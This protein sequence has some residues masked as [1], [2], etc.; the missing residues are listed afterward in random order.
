MSNWKEASKSNP[1]PLC[2]KPDWCSATEDGKAVLCR[3]TDMAPDGWKMLPTRTKDGFPIFAV[4][5]KKAVRPKQSRSWTYCNRNGNPLVRVWRVDDGKGGKPA[6]WQERWTGKCWAKGLED[7]QRHD[8]PVYRYEEVQNAITNDQAIFIVEGEV[9]ADILWGMG[10]PATTNIGGAGKWTASDTTDLTGAKVVLC[11]DRDEPGLR[12]MED[13]FK[14]FPDAQWLFAFPDSLS[15]KNPPKSQGVDVADWVADYKLTADDIKKA[16][17]SRASLTEQE[18]NSG[19]TNGLLG[20]INGFIDQNLLESEL[21]EKLLQ[22]SQEKRQPVQ[23]LW[24]LHNTLVQERERKDHI[25]SSLNGF[26]GLLNHQLRTEQ[27]D[28]NNIFPAPLMKALNSKS[29]AARIQPIFL[30]QNLLPAVGGLMGSG[31]GIVAKEGETEADH[32]IEY[33][34][35]WSATIAPP[36]AGKS[37]ANR[38]MFKPIQRLQHEEAERY[39][40]AILELEAVQQRWD[41]YSKDEKADLMDELDNP[42]NFRE[43]KVGSCR[44]FLLSEGEIEAIKR[45]LSEQPASAGCSWVSDELLGLFKGLDQYK[46]NDRGNARQFLLDAWT[47]PLWGDVERVDKKQS[48][49]FKG[50]TLNLCGGIQVE[51]AAQFFNPDG[52]NTDADGLQ[53]RI[54]VAAPDL[55]SDFDV[56]SDVKVSLDSLLK[57]LYQKVQKLPKGLVS[58][59]ADTKV[60]WQKQWERYR[61]SSRQQEQKNPAFAYFLGKMCS[62]LMRLALVLHAIEHC[63]SPKFDFLTLEPETFKKAIALAGYYISQFR[64]VQTKFTQQPEQ[65]MSEFLLNVLN[66]CLREGRLTPSM[67]VNRWRRKPGKD[68]KSIRSAEVKEMFRV[69]AAARPQQVVFDGKTLCVLEKCDRVSQNAITMRS[70]DRIDKALQSEALSTKYDQCDRS[71]DKKNVIFDDF[72]SRDRSHL[73]IKTTETLATTTEN[74]AITRS[75]SDHILKNPIAFSDFPLDKGEQVEL[76]RNQGSPAIAH[77]FEGSNGSIDATQEPD[78]IFPKPDRVSGI[79]VGDWVRYKRSAP[80]GAMKVTCSKHRLE[81]LKLWEKSAL[82]R[83]ETWSEG[84]WIEIKHLEVVEKGSQPAS[85]EDLEDMAESGFDHIPEEDDSDDKLAEQQ[86]QL[87]QYWQPIADAVSRLTEIEKAARESH[88]KQYR[89]YKG[90][91]RPKKGDLIRNVYGKTGVVISVEKGSEVP[92]HIEWASGGSAAYSFKDLQDLEVRYE[93]D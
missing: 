64:L 53:S 48:I 1:C 18:S 20:I 3:R 68:G 81:V 37:V 9:C 51:L 59:S 89:Q 78:R 77:G 10:I 15:W 40:R 33:G 50:Q 58:L 65:G 38:A 91:D 7:I 36:S 21:Q 85:S 84:Y 29:E 70:G 60:L 46:G 56:W 44:K 19:S 88:P 31:T 24:A 6:R 55:H 69:I 17:T 5:E 45:R 79:R 82:V 43:F 25:D 42:A 67:V 63:Y 52:K 12:H 74:D 87:K 2:Q 66:Y 92:F 54:L 75:H 39:E 34:N 86:E 22:V 62:N 27:I 72:S 93:R 11:P 83:R 90:N 49:R 14:N 8:I 23:T 76:T 47:G 4:E 30:I 16:V 57:E 13:I 73:Y 28:W 26:E 35:I 71:L 32:W 41:L 80:E 61:R